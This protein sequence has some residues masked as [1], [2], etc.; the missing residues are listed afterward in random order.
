MRFRPN[1]PVGNAER[2]I[3]RRPARTLNDAG[4]GDVLQKN[5]T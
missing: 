4:Y 1:T 3:S 5:K 2:S